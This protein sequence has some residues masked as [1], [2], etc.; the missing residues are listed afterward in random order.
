[1]RYGILVAIGFVVVALVVWPAGAAASD[2]V[3][4]LTV[5]VVDQD[6][7]PVGGTTVEATWDGGE[8]TATTASN[9][10]V[11]IDVARG[12]DVE[13]DIDDDTYV[14][15]LPLVV[16]DADEREVELRVSRQAMAAV[17]VV[18]ADEQPLSGATVELRQDG[19]TVAEGETGGDG[20]F[21]TDIIERGEYRVSA[22]K[23]GFYM[24]TIDLTVDA[25]TETEAE[26][27]LERGRVALDVD[28]VDNHFDPPRG[29][30]DARVL[31]EADD[32]D[33]N[34]RA[35]DGSASLNVPVNTRYT[36]TA[37]KD[38]YDGTP[39]S[40]TVREEPRSVTVSAQ[41]TP[42]LVVEPSNSRVIVGETT[43]IEVTN[44][45][46]EAVPGAV[47]TLDGAEM[48]ETD[49]RGELTITID[50]VGEQTVVASAGRLDSAPVTVEGIDPDADDATPTPTPTEEPEETP[51]F[52]VA[53]AAAAL[54]A[55][56]AFGYRLRDR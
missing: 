29:L 36:I 32:F 50:T 14:R 31:V 46:G 9:G 24:E 7:S 6:D 2:D 35:S 12:A 18:D 23:P 13:L 1:M 51:G 10:K 20:V 16:E 48:G 4:T 33:A 44:A 52:G 34:V 37:S 15:N 21:T 22:V 39:R 27:A 43:R 47:V 19:Q 5:S 49:D 26:I 42:E 25:E 3:V 38:G 41:R 17:T 11:F 55:V 45:Y 54:V 28:I 56:F 30:D 8:A 40:L 53:I